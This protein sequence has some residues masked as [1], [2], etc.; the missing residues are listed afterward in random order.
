MEDLVLQIKSISVDKFR[1]IIIAFAIVLIVLLTPSLPAWLTVFALYP[2][3]TSVID[4][5]LYFRG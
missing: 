5:A 4:I 1:G 3:V 2:L